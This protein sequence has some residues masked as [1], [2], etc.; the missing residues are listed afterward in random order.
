MSIPET[1]NTVDDVVDALGGTFAVARM[2]GRSPQAVSNARSKGEL[3]AEWHFVMSEALKGLG[4]VA[5]PALW[6][7]VAS[8]PMEART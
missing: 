6:R 7:Q 2:T 5:S 4:L 1:L 8:E 3:P